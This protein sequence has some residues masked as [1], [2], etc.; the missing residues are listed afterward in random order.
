MHRRTDKSITLFVPDLLGLTDAFKHLPE[1]DI[2][3]LKN[4][5]RFL[6]RAEKKSV[7]IHD[8]HG[9][10]ASLFQLEKLPA[11]ALSYRQ[12]AGAIEADHFYLCADPVY[13][14]PDMNSAVLL[15]HEELDLSLEDTGELAASV[16][17]HF[18]DE[19]WSLEVLRTHRWLI[20]LTRSPLLTTTPLARIKGQP[21]GDNLAQGNDSPYWQR[22]LNEI[23]MLLFAHPLN[24][25][26]EA[27]GKLPVN[28]LWLWGEGELANKH[29]D[30]QTI[31]GRGELLD[32]LMHYEDCAGK[33]M[34]INDELLIEDSGCSLLAS[35]EFITPVQ[36]RDIDA[37]L[38]ALKQFENNW[39]DPLMK[40]LAAGKLDAI[41]LLVGNSM[42]F[43][44]NRKMLKRWWRRTKPIDHIL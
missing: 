26:R 4:L 27:E 28:S 38:R 12:H 43:S 32:A 8:W 7:D 14:Q 19:S 40:S 44:L 11:A 33:E 37:W 21:I 20:K 10:L 36:A 25:Q 16:N 3:E 13:I 34:S 5:Q 31:L 17:A 30:W 15:A 2:P 9:G 35:D 29:S 39:L 23:Q 1:S 42:Q 6:S 18:V 24:Q 22:I 41:D